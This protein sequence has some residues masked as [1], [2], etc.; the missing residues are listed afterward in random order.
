MAELEILSIII[1]IIIIITII[2]MLDFLQMLD[3]QKFCSITKKKVHS[4]WILAP[5]FRL[6]KQWRN[7]GDI[8]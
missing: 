1:I 3:K 5:N 7:A 6:D 8:P 4:F 2:I